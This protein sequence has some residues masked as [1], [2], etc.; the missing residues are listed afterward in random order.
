M[1][2]E[3]R[4]RSFSRH[5]KPALESRAVAASWRADPI[6]ANLPNMQSP[7]SAERQSNAGR[8]RRAEVSGPLARGSSCAAWLGRCPGIGLRSAHQGGR[9]QI[10]ICSRARRGT[11]SACGRW[12]AVPSTASR[13][14][15]RHRQGMGEAL[16][17]RL[18]CLACRSS[19]LRIRLGGASRGSGPELAHCRSDATK[20]GV[21]SVVMGLWWGRVAC[22]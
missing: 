8:P 9:S 1:S 15:D 14:N 20:R 16:A 17:L 5:P 18:V 13:A 6:V 12:P 21:A 11:E 22:W 2:R 19:G 4:S 10:D 3:T 7:R